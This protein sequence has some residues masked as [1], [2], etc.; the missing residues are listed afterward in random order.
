MKT[1]GDEV[2]F[3]VG[4]PR[5][6]AATALA[7]AGDFARDGLRVRI[8]MAWGPTVPYEGDLFGPTVNLASRLVHLARPGAVIVDQPL[9]VELARDPAFALRRLRPR[10][11]GLGRVRA[12]VLRSR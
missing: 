11:K 5:T 1:I 2:M 10:L 8:G 9:G 7:L 6:A 3:A 12:W 4:E